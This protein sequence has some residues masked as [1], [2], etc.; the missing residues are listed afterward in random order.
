MATNTISAIRIGEDS[1]NLCDYWSRSKLNLWKTVD[2][3]ASAGVSL[4]SAKTSF[5]IDW[6]TDNLPSDFST[7]TY[8]GYIGYNLAR[9]GNAV[10]LYVTALTENYMTI[11]R[12]STRSSTVNP[13]AIQLYS[14]TNFD[15]N[16]SDNSLEPSVPD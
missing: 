2:R 11:A 1:Y 16:S 8:W 7:Y 3:S 13:T 5:Q 4:T 12:R 15:N 6:R 9:N 10:L 14:I